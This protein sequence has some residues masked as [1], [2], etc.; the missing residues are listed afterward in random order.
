MVKGQRVVV[1]MNDKQAVEAAQ[2]SQYGL[3]MKHP[4]PDTEIAPNMQVAPK[5]PEPEDDDAA[6]ASNTED[7]RNQQWRTSSSSS[8][9]SSQWQSSYRDQSWGQRDSRWNYEDGRWKHYWEK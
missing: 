2:R 1:D 5:T 6:E 8:S 3:R 7:N 9:W 4:E